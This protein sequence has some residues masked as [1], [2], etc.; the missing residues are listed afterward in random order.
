MVKFIAKINKAF[1]D[2][3][4][5]LEAPSQQIK[6]RFPNTNVAKRFYAKL[7]KL[8]KQMKDKIDSD[9]SKAIPALIKTFNHLARYFP[10]NDSTLKEVAPIAAMIKAG[11]EQK[12]GSSKLLELIQDSLDDMA[13][14]SSS[15]D[16]VKVFAVVKINKIIKQDKEQAKEMNKK[17]K[18]EQN[19]EPVV[20]EQKQIIKPDSNVNSEPLDWN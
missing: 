19:A 3:N 15:D 13:I 20:E 18:Q 8:T 17:K 14:P 6:E 11:D 12:D 5:E 7:L 16:N 4:I 1:T 10:V 9:P 2:S